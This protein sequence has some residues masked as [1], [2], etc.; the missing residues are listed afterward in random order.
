MAGRSDLNYGATATVQLLAGFTD[1]CLQLRIC[2]SVQLAS[3][4]QQ[5]ERL[6]RPAVHGHARLRICVNLAHRFR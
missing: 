1:A 2:L 4:P 6:L 3:G 5:S